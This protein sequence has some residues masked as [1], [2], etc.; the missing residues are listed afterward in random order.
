MA[1]AMEKLELFTIHLGTPP[2]VKLDSEMRFADAAA[3]Q[4]MADA[5]KQGMKDAE[6]QAANDPQAAA[7]MKM[8]KGAEPKVEGSSL[9]MSLTREQITE[10]A[11]AA[12]NEQ[13]K[14]EQARQQQQGQGQDE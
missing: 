6:A 10:L 8:M 13:A 14:Q 2:A 1:A 9:K 7:I 12:V 5:S 11:R 3:A 4:A